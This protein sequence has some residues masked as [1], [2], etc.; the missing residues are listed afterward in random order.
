MKLTPRCPN[1]HRVPQGSICPACYANVDPEGRSASRIIR[2]APHAGI[3]LVGSVVGVVA[4]VVGL[5]GVHLLPWVEMRVPTAVASTPC[6]SDGTTFLDERLSCDDGRL[7]VALGRLD[8]AE[9]SRTPGGGPLGRPAE[10]FVDWGAIT[11]TAA[12]GMTGL[13]ALLRRRAWFGPTVVGAVGLAWSSWTTFMLARHLPISHLGIGLHA[14]NLG[15]IGLLVGSRLTFVRPPA[16]TT[17]LRTRAPAPSGRGSS[18][19]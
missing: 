2:G 18:V 4:I 6:V 17:P 9:A 14:T 8:L 11:V 12:C 3:R 15:L 1:G 13:S 16:G 10:W 19:S 5:A 7:T